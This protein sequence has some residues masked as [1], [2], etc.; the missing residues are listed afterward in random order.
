MGCY[1]ASSPESQI[2]SACCNK[3]GV[4]AKP[5][6][7]KVL[8]KSKLSTIFQD[9]SEIGQLSGIHMILMVG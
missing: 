2:I 8:T 6:E 7:E 5:E 9:L 1:L 4:D 3:I